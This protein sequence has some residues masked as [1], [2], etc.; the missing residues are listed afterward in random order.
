MEI[1]HM[2]HKGKQVNISIFLKELDADAFSLEQLHQN[3]EEPS[4]IPII[5]LDEPIKVQ[6][7]STL[8]ETPKGKA[9][10]LRSK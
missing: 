5:K 2:H 3:H 1:K 10:D 7:H 4:K 9:T 6:L 8:A